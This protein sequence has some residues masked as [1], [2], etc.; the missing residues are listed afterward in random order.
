MAIFLSAGHHNNDSGAVANGYKENKLT[1]EFR[2]LVLHELQTKF[3]SYKVITD[4]D[5]ETLSQYLN[6]IKTGSGS[7]V[8]EIHFDAFNGKAKGATALIQDA[9]DK[10]DKMMGQELVNATANIL[11]TANRGVK[12]E[13]QSA[14]GKL[15]LTRKEGTTVLMEL[16]FIDNENAMNGY[17]EGKH[18][19]AQE[20]A[21]I[22]TKYDDLIK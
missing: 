18:R 21:R 1:I 3:P 5:E 7:V 20:Y 12:T 4:K 16:E 15:G 22:L 10:Y 2:D 13:S 9:H 19:L 8:L 11:G 14:R 17:H 6:R